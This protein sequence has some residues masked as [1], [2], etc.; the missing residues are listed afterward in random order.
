MW[1]RP[2]LQNRRKQGAFH[3]LLQEMRLCDRER[4]FGYLRMSKDTF[5]LLVQKV[6]SL[7]HCTSTGLAIAITTVHVYDV[8]QVSPYLFRRR[9]FSECRAE[10]SPAERLA[11]T[12]SGDSQVFER[13]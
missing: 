13:L 3:Q 5:D 8:L 12:A 9:Y 4:H 11:L 2:L 10:V 7:Q 1:V 6:R